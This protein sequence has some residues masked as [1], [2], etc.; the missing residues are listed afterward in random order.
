ALFSCH[1][2]TL[3][4][5]RTRQ[6]LPGTSPVSAK[7]C[8]SSTP[9]ARP[10]ISKTQTTS[11]RRARVRPIP[12]HDREC[13]PR[14][15]PRGNEQSYFQFSSSPIFPEHS[16]PNSPPRTNKKACRTQFTARLLHPS[17]LALRQVPVQRLRDLVLRHRSYNL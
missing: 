7:S 11:A 10:P 16:K 14:S 15:P 13:S 4:P 9:L 12:H 6:T 5:G 1:N 8:P 2:A 3:S 17:N